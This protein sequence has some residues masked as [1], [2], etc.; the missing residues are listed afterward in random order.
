MNLNILNEFRHALYRCFESARDSLFNCVDA[1]LSETQAQSLVE[2]SLSLFF[3]RKWPSLYEAFEDG[4]VDRAE[5]RQLFAKYAPHQEA[6]SAWLGVGVAAS[7]IA[8]PQSPTAEGRGCL[9]VH[10]LPECSKP[11]T[12]GWQFSM[13]AVLLKTTSSWCYV[14]ELLRITTEQ[15]AAQ[16]AAEQLAALAKLDPQRMLVVADRYYF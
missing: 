14:L 6:D 10:N 1:L 13:L 8:R 5:L 7:N 4:A 12:Y 3:E 16:V 9:F 15:T 11:I 2:L